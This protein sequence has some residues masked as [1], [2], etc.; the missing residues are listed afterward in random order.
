MLADDIL[1]AIGDSSATRTE[2]S[3]TT[4]ISSG[5]KVTKNQIKK[6]DDEDLNETALSDFIPL[7]TFS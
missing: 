5:K 7:R 3:D 4:K 2:K 6:F 1:D